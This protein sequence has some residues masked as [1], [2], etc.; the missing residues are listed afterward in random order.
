MTRLLG[1][2]RMS[3][4]GRPDVSTVC[5]IV[6]AAVALSAGL[7]LALD[8]S[9]RL[10]E[11]DHAHS[12]GRSLA[13]AVG[14][15]HDPS[16]HEASWSLRVP[17]WSAFTVALLAFL[18]L[19]HGPLTRRAA[20]AAI[21]SLSLLVGVLGLES[22]VHSVHHLYDAGAAQDCLVLSATQNLAG[23]CDSPADVTFLAPVAHAMPVLDGSVL[24]PV[25]PFRSFIGRAPP[26]PPSAA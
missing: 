11:S 22:A 26:A 3:R 13:D 10:D 4:G 20:R 5:L 7:F 12:W 15:A 21:T 8:T 23:T 24:P 14:Q 1:A 17:P 19:G 6:V 16:A 2:R 18:G 25:R 9:A